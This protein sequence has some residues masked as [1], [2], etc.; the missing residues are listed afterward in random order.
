MANKIKHMQRSHKTYGRNGAVFSGFE[1]KAYS[2]SFSKE[3]KKPGHTL[4]LLKAVF[5]NLFKRRQSR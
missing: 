1:R 4:E 3:Y 2:K 5:K